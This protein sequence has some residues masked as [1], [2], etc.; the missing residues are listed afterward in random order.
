MINHYDKIAKHYDF[1]SRLVFFKSQVNAQINQL[2]YIPKNSHILIVGG[3]TGWIL[4]EIAKI[5]AS[6][7]HIVYVEASTKMTALSKQKNSGS[8][9]VDFFTMNIENF[10][11]HNTFDIILTP[12]LFDNFTVDDAK[13]VFKKLHDILKN[14]GLWF[15]TDFNIQGKSSWWK[16]LFI[17]FMY[18]FFT[19]FK[20]INTQSLV[21]IAPYFKEHNYTAIDSKLYYGS[22]IEG[23]VY[24]K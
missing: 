12:F 7:L 1:L 2:K 9:T 10:A 5:H 16:L 20:I 13:S 18:Q 11:T 14:N 15:F 22:F 6:G 21:N 17:K 3:G 19:F 23:I 24:Q 4:E 8:N